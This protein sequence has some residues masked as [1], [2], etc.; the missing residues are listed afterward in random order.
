MSTPPTFLPSSLPSLP[1]ILPWKQRVGMA[2]TVPVLQLLGDASVL[3]AFYMQ[4]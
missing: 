3:L 1:L 2:R 4:H